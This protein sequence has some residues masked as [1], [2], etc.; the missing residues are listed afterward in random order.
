M[1]AEEAAGRLDNWLKLYGH[2]WNPVFRETEALRVLLKQRCTL[3]IRD[4]ERS[5]RYE[6][7]TVEELDRLRL[8][9]EAD[10][11][12]LTAAG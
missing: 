10:I 12:P 6:A 4:G 2:W 7:P 5:V 11:I 8:A 1:T 9:D 3:E